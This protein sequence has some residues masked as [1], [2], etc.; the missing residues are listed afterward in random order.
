MAAIAAIDPE[1]LGY[2]VDAD[3]NVHGYMPDYG[4][5]GEWRGYLYAD[6]TAGL[7]TKRQVR[8]WAVEVADQID[9]NRLSQVQQ[10]IVVT[11][12]VTAFYEV[13][14]GGAGRELAQE[15]MSVVRQAIRNTGT[16]LSNS[17]LYVQEWG[18]VSYGVEANPAAPDEGEMIRAQFSIV[19]ANPNGTI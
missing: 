18:T 10:N 14:V 7:S 11:A 9:I 2:P 16:T 15:H 8:A 3:I 12:T 4:A 17:V 1:D 5:S 6:V 19:A 13:G